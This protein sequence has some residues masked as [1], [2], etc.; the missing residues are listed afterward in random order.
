VLRAK[1]KVAVKRLQ[2][3]EPKEKKHNI[4]EMSF[5]SFCKHPNIV[6]YYTSLLVKNE[7]MV[8]S[9]CPRAS[10][11]VVC[12]VCGVCVVCVVC[13]VVCVVWCV[14]CV[15]VWCVVW[16]VVCGVCGVSASRAF[17]SLCNCRS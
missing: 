8:T 16:C 17:I 7:L 3:V 1:G 15:C 10:L 2:H 13:V 4:N 14:V 5:L 12:G 11:S 6:T 9:L